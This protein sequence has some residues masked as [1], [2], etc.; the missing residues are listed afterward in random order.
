MATSLEVGCK[1]RAELT[2]EM[3]EEGGGGEGG[4]RGAYGEQES[5][6]VSAATLPF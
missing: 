4:N 1:V 6:Y 2:G 3:G 5:R